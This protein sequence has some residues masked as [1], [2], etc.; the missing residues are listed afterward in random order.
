MIIANQSEQTLVL[1][2]ALSVMDEQSEPEDR[3]TH[4]HKVRDNY[5]RDWAARNTRAESRKRQWCEK[6]I[7]AAADTYGEYFEEE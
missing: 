1:D 6:C 5:D 4:C 3:C 2:A 7:L